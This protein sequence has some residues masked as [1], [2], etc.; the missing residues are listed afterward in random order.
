MAAVEDGI[1]LEGSSQL[2]SRVE[3]LCPRGKEHNMYVDPRDVM[4]GICHITKFGGEF[5]ILVLKPLLL[6][7]Y[8]EIQATEAII[9]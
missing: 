5:C 9:Q 8:T 3:C 7:C 6:G 1:A 4:S 2:H